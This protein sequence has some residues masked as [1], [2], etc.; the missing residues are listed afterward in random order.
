M[1]FFVLP[2][3]L[4]MVDPEGGHNSGASLEMVGKVINFVVLFGGLGFLLRKV[5]KNFFEERAAII[6]KELQDA[7]Q[8]RDEWQRR[9]EEIVDR[10]KRLDE[11]LA[12]IKQDSLRQ[13]EERK[14]EIVTL[15]Q[16]EAE[17]LRVLTKKELEWIYQKYLWS[18]KKYAVEMALG[19]AKEKIRKD[20]SSP[21]HH[22]LIQK[23]INNLDKVYEKFSAR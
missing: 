3:L 10:F 5:I 11:E 1:L 19:L 23:A 22:Q 14:K 20:L 17:R 8:E 13:A 18:L 16:K 15:A 7:A 12:R 4:F 2:I 21:A 9:C 6:E